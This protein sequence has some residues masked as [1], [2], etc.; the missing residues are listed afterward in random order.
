MNRIAAI[1]GVAA[2]ALYA[3][4]A[5]ATPVAIDPSASVG[6]PGNPGTGVCAMARHTTKYVLD[7]TDADG[8]LDG[9][10]TAAT[11][12]TTFDLEK[13]DLTNGTAAS[14]GDFTFD[15]PMPFSPS[16]A[17][18]GL[19]DRIAIRIDGLLRITDA[20][21]TTFAIR[22]DDG[23]RLR[24]GDQIV[25]VHSTLL[26][27]KVLSAQ[28]SFADPGLYPFEIVYFEN[29]IDAV[30]EWSSAPGAHPEVDGTDSLPDSSFALVPTDQLVRS[31]SSL[32]CGPSCSPCSSEKPFCVAGSCQAFDLLHPV[33]TGGAGGTGGQG[34]AGGASSTP[35][36]TVT[37]NAATGTE[38]ST[39]F[40]EVAGG[41][42]CS[43][44]R[45]SD[46]S[47]LVG[48]SCAVA[49]IVLGHRRRRRRA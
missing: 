48:T 4:T 6:L 19:G 44:T 49:A 45:S 29:L 14:A 20:G 31:D 22:S 8:L 10:V 13:V 18:P 36:T 42:R 5:N 24:I 21:L 35:A 37:S 1:A 17:P 9:P 34:G 39:G 28:V 46:P 30:L 16:G 3:W 2:T 41:A 7:L 15:Y 26:N 40:V 25:L 11:G 33:G 38:P 32:S 43:M 23:F 12:S 27:H 47:A